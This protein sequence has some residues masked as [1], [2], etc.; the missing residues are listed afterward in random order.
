M[1][2]E[3]H[4]TTLPS[5]DHH[6]W[7]HF[8]KVQLSSTAKPLLIELSGGQDEHPYWGEPM[9]PVQVMT[10]DTFVGEDEMALAWAFGQQNKVIEHG[11]PLVRAKLEVPLDKSGPYEGGVAYY[12][13]HV[14]SLIPP[15]D[16]S[17]MVEVLAETGW[18][19]S[20]NVWYSDEDGLEKWYFTQRAY[21]EVIETHRGKDDTPQRVLAGRE[22]AE[23]YNT[24]LT[25]NWH[26][27]RMESEAVI[28]DTNPDLDRGWT[29]A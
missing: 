15:A 14:K 19:A 25:F 8:T 1:L 16:V 27:V 24:L 21:P 10:A 7:I 17:R 3:L 11:F 26:T 6:A 18:H 13:T 28:I 23:S 22:F 5:V 4:L 2:Y 9:H 12:E 20:Q 29:E